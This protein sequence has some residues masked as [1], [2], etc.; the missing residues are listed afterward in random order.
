MSEISIKVSIGTRTYPL[1]VNP[2]EEELIRAA[3]RNVNE[4]IKV[5]QDNYAVKDIQDLLAMTALQMATQVLNR[6]Q[7]K[8]VSDQRL[9]EID[10]MLGRYLEK[11]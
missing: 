1:S 4:N 5:L 10:E 8:P 9:A 11:A 2:D 3:A 7:E 6:K